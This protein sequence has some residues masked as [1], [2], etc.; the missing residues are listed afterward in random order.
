MSTS[1]ERFASLAESLPL[2]LTRNQVIALVGYTDM[3]L[4][5]Q[6][7][8]KLFPRR[9]KWGP[10]KG[11]RVYYFTP[12]LLDWFQAKLEGRAWIPPKRDHREVLQLLLQWL[13]TTVGGPPSFL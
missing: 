5:R 9:I 11:G 4:H 2:F 6:E 7:N 8:R 10:G 12:D 1:I 3:T 13:A